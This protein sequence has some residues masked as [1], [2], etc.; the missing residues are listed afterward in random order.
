MQFD[1]RLAL[2]NSIL[3]MLCITPEEY[4]AECC[5]FLVASREYIRED[6]LERSFTNIKL[7]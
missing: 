7:N 1:I 2:E 3:Y 6:E 5:L 4:I